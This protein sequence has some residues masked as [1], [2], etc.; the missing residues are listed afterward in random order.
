MNTNMYNNFIM[1]YT[2]AFSGIF[3]LIFF[4]KKIKI[5]NKIIN[6]LG[7]NTFNNFCI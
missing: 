3:F 4:I 1:F 5:E 7:K 6:F 2:S